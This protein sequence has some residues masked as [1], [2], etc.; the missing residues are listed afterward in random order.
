M[1]TLRVAL[2][3]CGETHPGSSPGVRMEF[4]SNHLEQRAR[5][6]AELR[7]RLV[8]LGMSFIA[9]LAEHRVRSMIA[10]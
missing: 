4:G 10:S 5:S 3:T 6:G 2:G 9:V 1:T 8:S 7:N